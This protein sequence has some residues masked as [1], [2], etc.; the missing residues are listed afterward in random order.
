[1]DSIYEKLFEDYAVPIFQDLNRY[2]DE[3]GLTAQLEQL[4]LPEDTSRQ[5]EELFYDRYLQ[6]STDAFALGL[7]LG[8]SLLHD[9][10]R[11]LRPQQV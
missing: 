5:L 10:I 3:E 11:R 9:E 1:M 4:A 8:L 7:H 6:W 2:Y